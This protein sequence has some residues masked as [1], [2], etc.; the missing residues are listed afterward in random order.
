M[1]LILQ[2]PNDGVTE[3]GYAQLEGANNQGNKE[4]W[5]HSTDMGYAA[6]CDDH[7]RNAQMNDLAAR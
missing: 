4:K 5:C 6:Q 2:W 3:Q 7:T 1:N